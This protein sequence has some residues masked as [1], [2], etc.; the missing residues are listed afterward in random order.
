MTPRKWLWEER[1]EEEDIW[2]QNVSK[3]VTNTES[4]DISLVL[5]TH[6]LM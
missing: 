6:D 2:G 1:E 5:H 3:A 4:E